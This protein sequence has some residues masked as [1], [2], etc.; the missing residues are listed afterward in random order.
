MKNGMIIII[1]EEVSKNK[2]EH[3]RQ[4]DRSK[5][6]SHAA[7]FAHHRRRSSAS[8]KLY[9]QIH[10][11]RPKQQ[12]RS[13]AFF[14]ERT[15]LQ[16]PGWSDG[17]F[18]TSLAP[19]IA[20]SYPHVFQGLSA[21]ADYHQALETDDSELRRLSV[22]QGHQA[23]A[24]M[25]TDYLCTPTSVI[26][27]SCMITAALFALVNDHIFHQALKTLFGLLEGNAYDEFS[28]ISLV[29][30]QRSRICQML[31]PL[32][33]LREG[34]VTDSTPFKITFQTLPQAR[35][36]LERVLND[37]ARQMKSG[38][39]LCKSAI[40]DWLATFEALRHRVDDTGW[41]GLRAAYGMSLVQIETL[42]KA[43]CRLPSCL[44]VLAHRL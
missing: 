8:P 39:P 32:T 7:S 3:E 35:D 29:K 28:L 11:A 40:T 6:R 2:T 43:R 14:R 10:S 21:I 12:L 20:A 19:C 26:I 24:S 5:A 31:D 37:G 23:I 15:S 30:R 22:A 44:F 38:R 16:W 1:I 18:W 17:E 9:R 33:V 27:V 42:C 13:L 34:T 36:S 4:L 25:N 41:L